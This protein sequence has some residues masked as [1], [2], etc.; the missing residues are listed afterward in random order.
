MTTIKFTESREDA[1]RH[2]KTCHGIFKGNFNFKEHGIS[3][4]RNYNYLNQWIHTDNPNMTWSSN[5]SGVTE[6]QLFDKVTWTPNELFH[7]TYT[8]YVKI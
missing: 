3:G 4:T 8:R 1:T 2:Q 5:I 6:K 7:M